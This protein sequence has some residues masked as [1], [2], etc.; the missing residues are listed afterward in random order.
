MAVPDTL[1][2]EAIYGDAA[3]GSSSEAIALAGTMLL[4]SP[5]L[6]YYIIFQRQFV[7]SIESSGITGGIRK[8]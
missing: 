3:A 2:Y 1:Q 7:K 8:G 6:I 4:V 5:L